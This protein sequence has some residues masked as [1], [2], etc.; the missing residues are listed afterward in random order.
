MQANAV[1]GGASGIAMSYAK[2]VYDDTYKE[3]SENIDNN[4]ASETNRLFD[5]YL[6][7]E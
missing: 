6:N 5:E 4:I 3:L 7:S 1:L 2:N